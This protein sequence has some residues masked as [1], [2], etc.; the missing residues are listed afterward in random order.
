MKELSVGVGKVRAPGG[1]VSFTQLTVGWDI[2]SPCNSCLSL[3]ISMSAT[4]HGQGRHRKCKNVLNPSLGQGGFFFAK[5]MDGN[6]IKVP[7]GREPRDCSIGGESC[8][9]KL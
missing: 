2:L 1:G 4:P 7:G 8:N 6:R 3:S 9:W 5:Q